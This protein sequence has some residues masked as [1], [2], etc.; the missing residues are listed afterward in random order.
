MT[1]LRS[2]PVVLTRQLGWVRTGGNGAWRDGV[3][4]GTLAG[5][6]MLSSAGLRLKRCGCLLNLVA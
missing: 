4:R 1:F 3:R 2:A 6:A 5:N